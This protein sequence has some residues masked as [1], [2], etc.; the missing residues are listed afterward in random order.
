[1]G[2]MD[3]MRSAQDAVQA[4]PARPALEYD[5]DG[6]LEYVWDTNALDHSLWTVEEFEAEL[7]R[8]V[9]SDCPFADGE[10]RRATSIAVLR[11]GLYTHWKDDG[12]WEQRCNAQA[13]VDVQSGQASSPLLEPVHGVTLSDY[14]QINIKLAEASALDGLLQA[15]GIDPVAWGEASLVWADRM[16]T[17]T[18]F[19][20]ASEYGRLYQAGVTDPRLTGVAA[21]ILTTNP[22]NLQR[23]QSD[24]AFATEMSAARSAA[25]SVGM[26]GNQW[27]FDTIGVS[28]TDFQQAEN[29]WHVPWA[30]QGDRSFLD[31]T[32]VEMAT[33][34][35]AAAEMQWADFRQAKLDEYTRMFVAQMGGGVADDISF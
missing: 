1:M 18:T 16:A 15:M 12:G 11:A 24:R 29:Q 13:R 27:L 20:V 3:R 9:K 22:A 30:E 5:E 19:V 21:A 23:L 31:G 26:D 33:S 28:P 8:R 7:A 35:M 6:E 32:S 2:F 25:Y 10:P 4:Q 14:T 34:D 17:D